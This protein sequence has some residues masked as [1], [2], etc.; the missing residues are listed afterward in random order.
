MGK[1]MKNKVKTIEDLEKIYYG[2]N[3]DGK[4][5]SAGEIKN[6]ED[7]T[8]TRFISPVKEKEVRDFFSPIRQVKKLSRGRGKTSD[9]IIESSNIVIEVS[10]LNTVVAGEQD[11]DGNIPINLPTGEK[12]FIERINRGVEHAEEKED[13]DG[14]HRIGVIFY[15]H[16]ILAL[17]SKLVDQLFKPDFIRKTYFLSSSVDALI[18]LPPRVGRGIEIPKPVGYVK[19]ESLRKLLR[20]IKDLELKLL[21]D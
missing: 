21:E 7:Y 8:R 3:I 11:K 15:D 5:V 6:Y 9:Y 20:K 10:S 2:P 18:F 4:N 12:E 13:N 1:R 16:V 14:R 19:N 17:Q